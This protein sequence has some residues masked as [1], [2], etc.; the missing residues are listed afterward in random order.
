MAT[1][2]DVYVVKS[3]QSQLHGAHARFLEK[4]GGLCRAHNKFWIKE[5]AAHSPDAGREEDTLWGVLGSNEYRLPGDFCGVLGISVV[6]HH[7]SVPITCERARESGRSAYVVMMRE[8]LEKM[9]LPLDYGRYLLSSYRR[10]VRTTRIAL[11]INMCANVITFHE[12]NVLNAAGS[13]EKRAS[14]ASS[15]RKTV[16]SSSSNEYI[17]FLSSSCSREATSSSVARVA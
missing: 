1:S 9:M 8:L 6:R 3:W 10:R 16:S 12:T 15:S 5:I 2:V 7:I 11:S 13:W 4:A 14:I 17:E